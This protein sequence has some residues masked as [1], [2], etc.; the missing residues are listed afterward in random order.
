MAVASSKPLVMERSAMPCG[1]V[2]QP[3]SHQ[4]TKC[5][6]AACSGR[7]GARHGFSTLPSL[8]RMLALSSDKVVCCCETYQRMQVGTE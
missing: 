8:V 5:H 7:Q 3:A 1:P 6:T 4:R 2:H